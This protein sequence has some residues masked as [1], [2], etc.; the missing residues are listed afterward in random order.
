MEIVQEIRN[1]VVNGKYRVSF[2]REA[3]ASR[4]IDGF[5]VEVNDDTQVV[6]FAQ[7][8]DLYQRAIVLTEANKPKVAEK[9]K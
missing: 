3:N 1:V 8:E 7:A 5:T 2:K 4:Q 6:A 9:E